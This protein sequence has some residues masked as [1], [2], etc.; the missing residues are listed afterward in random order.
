LVKSGSQVARYSSDPHSNHTEAIKRLG[1]YLKENPEK[2][3]FLRPTDHSFEV[4]ADADFCGLWNIEPPHKPVSAKSRTGYVIMYAGCPIIWASQLQTEISLST[5]EAEYV[6]LSSALRNTI[7]L[8]R[9][10]GEIKEQVNIPMIEIPTVKCRAFEDNSGAVELSKVH[11]MRPRT[12]HFNTKYH[13]FRR[14]VQNKS[15]NVMQVPTTE[16]VADIL[17][18]TYQ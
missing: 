12:K 14:Y 11:K 13:H 17:Q 7:P 3:M 5:T 18:R 16:Q 8:M 15:I 6:A 1:R 9:L 2:G 4:Y 10:T